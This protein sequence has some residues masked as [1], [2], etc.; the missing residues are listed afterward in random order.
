M[1]KPSRNHAAHRAQQ[2][3]RGPRSFDRK[4]VLALGG[5]LAAVAIALAI[6][7]TGGNHGGGG[8]SNTGASGPSGGKSSLLTGFGNGICPLTDTPAPGGAVPNRPALA[9]KIGNEPSG[10][11]P[12]SGLNEADIVYDTPAEGGVMRYIAV[13][14]CQNAS[15]IGPVRSVRW[16]DW[17]IVR[18]FVHPILAYAGGIIPDVN[19]VQASTW[20]ENADLL[21][22]AASTSYRTTNRVPPDNLYTS[23]KALYAFFPSAKTPPPPVFEY[24]SKP[25]AVAKPLAS[26]EINFSY[27]T[28]GVWT[29]NGSEWA[30]SY[31]NGSSLSPDDDAL[32]NQQVTTQNVVIQVVHYHFGP[33]AESPGST[34][35]VESATTGSGQGWVLRN[36]TMTPVT[37]HRRTLLDPTTFTAANGSAVKLAPGRTFVEMVIN[38]TA[39]R[40]GAITF[41]S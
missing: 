1:S 15:A 7:L 2:A 8:G 5:V 28:D 33:Y 14:Q 40:S 19:K 16:V 25:P 26:V 34:G 23:T 41:K 32:T 39:S 4:R 18:A 22:S 13:Y 20:L 6:V 27:N 29:W 12:Q 35:D 30:H 31:A 17:H 11:R 10:A 36:G 3:P 37:W 24:S 21:A 9:V 38:T